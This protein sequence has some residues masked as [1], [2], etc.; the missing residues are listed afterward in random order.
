MRGRSGRRVAAEVATAHSWLSHDRYP[1]ILL[2]LLVTF[3]GLLAIAPRDRGTWALEN[4]LLLGGVVALIATRRSLPLSRVS[5]T[6]IFI[7]L[8][9][10]SIGAHYT[11]SQVPYQQWWAQLTGGSAAEAER[12][13]RTFAMS[14][15]GT[16]L[17]AAPSIR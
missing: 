5:Y 3:A 11:Y 8:C 15:R 9:F 13:K 4:S 1:A 2:A 17:S 16:G 14:A 12:Q 7:F 6:L 10:H